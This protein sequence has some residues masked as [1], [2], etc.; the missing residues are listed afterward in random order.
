MPK[1]SEDVSVYRGVREAKWSQPLAKS[2]SNPSARQTLLQTLE[3][4]PRILHSSNVPIYCTILVFL[5]L[6]VLNVY[7]FFRM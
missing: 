6:Q 7:L 3:Q 2:S 1:V 5:L 4:Q